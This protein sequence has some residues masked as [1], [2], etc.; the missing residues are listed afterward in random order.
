MNTNLS[1]LQ[2]FIDA[3][4]S[5]HIDA[6]KT[7][8][9]APEIRV[10]RYQEFTFALVKIES[11]NLILGDCAVLFQTDSARNW[12][13]LVDNTDRLKA[14]LLPLSSDR[15]V[16]GR[17]GDTSVDL[18]NVNALIARASMEFFIGN[19]RLPLYD[20]LAATIASDAFP[21]TPDQLRVLVQGVIDSPDPP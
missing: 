19:A 4:N 1:V 10:R 8:D 13:P 6:L 9:A 3:V 16:V 17:V 18:E 5:G 11:A 20:G 21:M 15:L 7:S 12:K 14:V 2:R